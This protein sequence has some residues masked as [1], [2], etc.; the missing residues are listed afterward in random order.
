MA[1]DSSKLEVDS[2]S[3]VAAGPTNVNRPDNNNNLLRDYAH[4]KQAQKS[5]SW[6]SP[7]SENTTYSLFSENKLLIDQD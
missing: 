3:P 1:V 4:D 2:A 7:L 6:A 5:T